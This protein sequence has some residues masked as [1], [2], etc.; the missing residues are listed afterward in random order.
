MGK[1]GGRGGGKWAR[2]GTRRRMRLGDGEICIVW[3]WLHRSG[4]P[5]K[6]LEHAARSDDLENR[7][8]EAARR[9]MDG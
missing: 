7:R 5:D 6:E 9:Q 4:R 8:V 3:H 1:A 2:G